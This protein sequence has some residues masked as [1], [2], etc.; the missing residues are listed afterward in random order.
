MRAER[1]SCMYYDEDRAQCTVHT[2]QYYTYTYIS[3][4]LISSCIAWG[5]TNEHNQYDQQHNE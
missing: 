5:L 4:M 3:G 1:S 2:T